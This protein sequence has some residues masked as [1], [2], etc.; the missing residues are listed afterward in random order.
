MKT[1][2]ECIF[3]AT[4]GGY[5]PPFKEVVAVGGTGKGADTAIV[6]RSTFSSTVFSSAPQKRFV[7][8]EILA[9]PRNKTFYKTITMEDWSIKET[10]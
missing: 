3:M 6:A 10:K 1:A 2:V 8:K 7:I 9:M 5:I 4:D